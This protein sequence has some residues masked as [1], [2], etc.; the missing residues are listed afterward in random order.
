MSLNPVLRGMLLSTAQVVL[1]SAAF[2]LF[3]CEISGKFEFV[4]PSLNWVSLKSSNGIKFTAR[5]CH[6]TTTYKG[7]IYVT[8]GKTDLYKM[9]N[10]LYSVK[11]A[12]VW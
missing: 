10:T 7:R 3:V 5:N 8:G 12:D 11:A 6:A 1:F 4:E 9:W 2:L